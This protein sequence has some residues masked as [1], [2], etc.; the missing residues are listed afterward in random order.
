M[1]IGAPDIESSTL[2][3]NPISMS[4][5]STCRSASFVAVADK[6]ILYAQGEPAN[7][8]FL[9]LDGFVKTSHICEDGTEI[10][11][12]LLKCGEIAGE[13]SNPQLPLVYEETARAIGDVVAQ[14]VLANDLRAAMEVNPRLAIFV[15]EHLAGSKRWVQ[16][17]LL[18]AMTQSVEWRVIETLVELAGTFGAQCPH[19][20]SLEIRL[21]QQDIADFVGAS[22]QVVSSILS[23]LRRRGLLD[24]TRD[25]ICINDSALSLLA[26]PPDTSPRAVSPI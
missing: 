17:R 15:A 21:T 26:R 6:A 13:F 23:D 8:L 24:Y 19:G 4:V 5:K 22:R 1:I 14:R 7:A 10:T 20:F 11:M 12:D 2:N 9:I 25:M 18:R 3:Q 16:R